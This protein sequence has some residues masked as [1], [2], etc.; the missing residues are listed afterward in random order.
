MDFL[1]LEYAA[2]LGGAALTY[3]LLPWQQ[4]R[5]LVLL[6]VS[7]FFYFQIQQQYVWLLLV[8]AWVNFWVAGQLSRSAFPLRQWLLVMGIG[9]NTLLLVGFK[10]IPF[11]MTILA[12]ATGLRAGSAIAEWARSSIVAPVT[13]SFYVF[14]LLAYLADV[15]GGAAPATN[16]LEFA[17]YKLFFTKLL[18]GPITRYH[19]FVPQLRQIP[20]WQSQNLW[21][22]LWLITGGIVKKG[23]V[24]DNFGVFVDLCLRNVER[25]GSGDLWLAIAA[26]GIQIYFDFSGYID[27]VRG[28]AQILGFQLPINFDFPYWA[29]SVSEFWRR[30]HITL[31][32]WM[33]DYVYIP[34]GGSR[35]GLGRTCL[36]LMLVMLVVGIWHGANWGFILWG[37]WHGTA[38]VGH[39]MLV[40]AGWGVA[41]WRTRAGVVVA[42]LATQLVVLV[43]WIPFRLP[44]IVDL[45]QFCQR[46]WGQAADPQFASKIYVQ[47]L[48]LS[49]GQIGLLLLLVLGWH[50]LLCWGDRRHL[51]LNPYVKIFAIPILLFLGGL[52][53]PE[54]R[55]PFIYFDF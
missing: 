10:Y 28:S 29:T 35:G 6:T 37:A 53:S 13:L 2:L 4:V 3:W 16:F 21:Q 55:L 1:S 25:A 52:M 49:A 9:L 47:S 48:G 32:N 8:M 19:Q 17:T 39:R 11:L 31:G 44:D 34:L 22:G 15:Y 14:E 40:A 51:N 18:S 23:V 41:F 24:A 45:S 20:V 30:W 46:L 27:I 50:G 38:L 26:Y 43:G 5:W 54:E 12:D 33:R 7:L 36:N 42:W